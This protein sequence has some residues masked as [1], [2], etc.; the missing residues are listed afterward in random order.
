M[1][2]GRGAVVTAAV[3]LALALTAGCSSGA[4]GARPA[5][6]GSASGAGGSGPPSGS[7]STTARPVPGPYV[8][9]GDSYT[10]G[11]Q[12]PPPTGIPTGCLRSGANYPSLVAAQLGLSG[13]GFRDVSCNGARTTNLTGQ[14]RTS[15][16]T[17]PP[18]LDAL[19]A[20][21]RLV[22]VGIGGNDAGFMDVLSRCARESL[23]RS[24]FPGDAA[25]APCRAAYAAPGGGPDEVQRKV[26]AA[27]EKVTAVLGEV[28]RRAPQATVYLVGYPILFPA[29]GSSCVQTLGDAVAPGDL[30]FLAEKQQQLNAMLRDSARAAGARFVDTA[31]ASVGHDMCAGPGRRWIEPVV[32]AAGAAPLHPN[33]LGEKGMAAAVLAAVR[34]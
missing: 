16:G 34:G 18:Q 5:P 24:Q 33:A 23:R 17:N 30:A 12:V 32:P 2:I 28:R 14:Q 13:A 21:T 25:A 15:D 4:D 26:E 20:Q 3:S 27:G 22:T 29:D 31:A 6:A 1:G 19:G 11:P 7:P 10:S 8:A 9:L